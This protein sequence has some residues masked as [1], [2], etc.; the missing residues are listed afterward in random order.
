MAANAGIVASTSEMVV[1]VAYVAAYMK[2]SWLITMPTS[3]ENRISGT[4]R[5]WTHDRSLARLAR[6]PP[7]APRRW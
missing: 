3:A 2:P 1:A 5:R 4:S 7:A 6:T